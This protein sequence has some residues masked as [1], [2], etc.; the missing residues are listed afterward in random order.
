MADTSPVASG[1]P[2][3]RRQGTRTTRLSARLAIAVS[4]ATLIAFAGLI[5]AGRWHDEYLTLHE[6]HQSG[7]DFLWHRLIQWS[8]R[9]LSEM[10]V[11]F[12]GLAVYHTGLPLIGAFI[13]PFWV[14]LVA[15]VLWPWIRNRRLLLPTAV[16]LAML[17]L[18]HP[19]A[20]VFYWPFGV[21]AYL[22]T[23]TAAALL[24]TLD[25]GGRIESGAGSTWIVV[26]LTIAAASSEVGALFCVIY[27]GTLFGSRSLVRGRPS[28]L[29]AIPLL[30]S[31]TVLFLQY[32]GRV[33]H[34][35]EVFGDPAVAYHPVQTLLAAGKQVLFELLKGGNRHHY[36][37]LLTGVTTK[38]L[39]FAGVYMAMSARNKDNVD[40]RSQRMRLAL[41]I[42][43]VIT[44][45]LIMA[46]SLYNFGA[47]CCERHDTMRQGYV[48]VALGSLATWLA[49]RRPSRHSRF[50]GPLLLVALLIPL[51]SATPKLIANYRQ[52]AAA[53]Q[54]SATTWRSGQSAGPNMQVTQTLPGPIT[55]GLLI[56]PGSYRRDRQ[57]HDDI[58]WMLTFFNK[59]S[60]VV[61]APVE[62]PKPMMEARSSKKSRSSNEAGSN[63]KPGPN[64]IR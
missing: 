14:A 47:V 5:P 32:T 49:V 57:A 1:G 22:P 35:N 8:P 31:V 30:L 44:A 41:T 53:R 9:P 7:L 52:Y 63:N 29:F 50:A 16:L 39:F 48:L 18:G 24:L 4:F 13:T 40:A 23:L 10:L 34:G 12:Y 61:A 36:P 37:A 33:E 56:K 3:V 54:A 2:D 51:G 46:A 28:L 11:Y 64:N 62:T 26:A 60:A 59:K 17:L 58:H 6:Y 43:A 55:G 42:A 21:V 38:A 20:E 15:A 19:V 27:I 45:A 25:W